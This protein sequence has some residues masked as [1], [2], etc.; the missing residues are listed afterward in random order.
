[1]SY[2]TI[3]TDVDID[4]DEISDDYLL[5]IIEYKLKLYKGKKNPKYFKDFKKDVLEVLNYDSAGEPVDEEGTV[6]DWIKNKVLFE[7][8]TKYTLDELETFLN[9][10]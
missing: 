4:F 8:V 2:I 1:M 6:Q 5:E 10:A 9:K 3:T 7:L